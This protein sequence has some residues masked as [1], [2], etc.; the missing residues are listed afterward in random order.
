MHFGLVSWNF[1][2]IHGL[3]RKMQL[4]QKLLN[5]GSRLIP[6]CFSSKTG[7]FI[8][9]CEIPPPL[10]VLVPRHD[11]PSFEGDSNGQIFR[12]FILMT[13]AVSK[14]EKS[15]NDVV[16]DH[17]LFGSIPR[18]LKKQSFFEKISFF[19]N[20]VDFSWNSVWRR[21]RFWSGKWNMW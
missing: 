3:G 18:F 13:H 7:Q 20:Q 21:H 2:E 6:S 12:Y 15:E 5:W 9:S 8:I 14:H 16:A 1:V 19:E 17:P 10:R 11:R 4:H